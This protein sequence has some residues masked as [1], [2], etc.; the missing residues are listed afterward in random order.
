MRLFRYPIAHAYRLSLLPPPP[1][2]QPIDQA[3]I[4][5]LENLEVFGVSGNHISL[6]PPSIAALTRLEELY[7]GSKA[8]GNDISHLPLSITRLTSLNVLVRLPT[9][10]LLTMLWERGVPLCFVVVVFFIFL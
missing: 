2:T 9:V 10:V 8:Y 4:S 1:A 6:V 5:R 7:L 3:D